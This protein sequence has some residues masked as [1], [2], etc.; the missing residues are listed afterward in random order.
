[1]RQDKVLVKYYGLRNT[2]VMAGMPETRHTQ[3]SAVLCSSKHA[4]SVAR[5]V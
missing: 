3:C 1:M 4:T 2:K 5:H